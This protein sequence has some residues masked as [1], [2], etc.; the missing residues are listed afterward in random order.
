MDGLGL[1]VG[2]GLSDIKKTV[3]VNIR[4]YLYTL[5][6]GR[7][8]LS[9]NDFNADDIASIRSAVDRVIAKTGKLEGEIGYGDYDPKG[10]IQA[11]DKRDDLL[12]LLEKSF[13]NPAFRMETT[14][15]MAKYHVNPKGEVEISDAYD[16]NAD[17]DAVRKILNT[18][19]LLPVLYEGY[20]DRGAWGLANALGN[21]FG[22]TENEGTPYTLNLGKP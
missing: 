11:E 20:R 12:S 21:I 7:E 19:G 1:N 5:G 17:R 22:L 6:G 10:K 2:L 3:P 4:Q 18:Q 13:T 8:G 16:F 14:L 15:G 9:L